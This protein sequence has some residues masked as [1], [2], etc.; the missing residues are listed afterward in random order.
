MSAASPNGA[1]ESEADGDLRITDSSARSSRLAIRNG[2]GPTSLPGP[3]RTSWLEKPLW[4]PIR[5][6][7]DIRH[8]AEIEPPLTHDRRR[9]Y[10]ATDSRVPT[11]LEYIESKRGILISDLLTSEDHIGQLLP[12]T[13]TN[14]R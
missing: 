12:L 5:Q 6:Y 7:K 8:S 9:I 13:Q 3:L 4:P 10:I 1:H 11:T 2:P 14:R